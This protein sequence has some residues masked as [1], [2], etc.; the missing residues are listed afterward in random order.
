MRSSVRSL[1]AAILIGG[2]TVV[3]F[4]SGGFF[5]RPRLI[6]GLAAWALVIA[7]ALVGT[8]PLPS[9]TAGRIALAGLFGL[10]AWTALS[11]AWAPLGGR[12]QDDLQRLLL[13]LGFFVASLALLRGVG[14][15]RWLEPSL[16]LSALVIVGYALSE[17]LLPGLIELDRSQSAS[18]RLEQPITYWNALGAIAAIGVV[19]AV[20]VAGDPERSKAMRGAAAAAGVPLCLGVYLSFSRGALA[21]VA[22]GLLVLLALAPAGRPQLRSAL[23][24]L[25]TGAA[26]ALVASRLPTLESLQSGESGVPAEGLV[27]LGCL[28][29]LAGA[30]A[31]L[32]TR[33]PRREARHFPLPVSRRAAVMTVTVVALLVAVVGAATLEGKPE[34][35]SP[36]PEARAARLGSIDTNRYRYWD[37]AIQGW[38]EKPI[39]GLG[40]GAFF[41]EWRRTGDRVDQS[42]DAHS[43]YLETAAELG[44][45]GVALLALLFGG[46]TAALVRLD[47]V[48]PRTATGLAAGLAAWA[49]HAG[50]DWDW[51]VPAVSLVAL[52]LAAAAIAWSEELPVR[53]PA[54]AAAGHTEGRRST[55]GAG[56]PGPSPGSRSAST[57]G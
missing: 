3:A 24:I 46:V 14:V 43:L 44:L 4:F 51:E 47:R 23:M 35:V 57:V 45:I 34:G 48:H 39:W 53:R 16:V 13:Y 26:A 11:M 10:T 42:A 30:A 38:A 9:S 36:D 22:A 25:V 7:A 55:D 18:G 50:L 1:A 19:L 5:D 20:R 8:R 52:L 56:Q 17:R 28:V 40:S 31:A 27:M 33:T 2:T 29:V 21:A 54:T 32:V 12:A 15:R 37:V 41:V 6:A 49:V